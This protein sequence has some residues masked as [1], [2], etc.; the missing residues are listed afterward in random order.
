MI[1]HNLTWSRSLAHD[2]TRYHIIFECGLEAKL[3][4]LQLFHPRGHVDD[5]VQET[6]EPN[7]ELATGFRLTGNRLEPEPA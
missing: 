5:G 3:C 6:R 1:S 4:E 2:F 7:R